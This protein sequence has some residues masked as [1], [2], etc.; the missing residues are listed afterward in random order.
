MTNSTETAANF[1]DTLPNVVAIV[2][3]RSF[4][5]L[6]WI[7]VFV[8]RLRSETIVVSGG[9]RGVDTV[10]ATRAQ[11]CGLRTKIFEIESWEWERYG[12]RAGMIRNA[13]LLAYVRELGGHVVAFSHDDALGNIVGGTKHVVNLAAKW[14]VPVTVYR[15]RTLQN[16]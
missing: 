1:F 4:P 14:N 7:D 16:V 9:A 5:H 15:S 13:V 8:E 2:G 6:H 11:K 10:A 3:S 12:R